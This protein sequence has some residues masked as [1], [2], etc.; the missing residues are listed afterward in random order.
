MSQAVTACWG[1]C[2]P[3]RLGASV[4]MSPR[5]SQT[6]SSKSSIRLI[7]RPKTGSAK[8]Q[9]RG[10]QGRQAED[11]GAG[12]ANDGDAGKM[13]PTTKDGCCM[14]MMDKSVKA[15]KRNDA[16][17]VFTDRCRRWD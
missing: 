17:V 7:A 8:T 5:P 6:N 10:E 12:G 14:V 15:P 9:L 1:R 16:H 13:F 11:R 4:P 3:Q 2:V